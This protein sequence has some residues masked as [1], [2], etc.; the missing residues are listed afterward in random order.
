MYTTLSKLPN[1]TTRCRQ[2]RFYLHRFR[3]CGFYFAPCMYA[4]LLFTRAFIRCFP[5]YKLHNIFL[6]PDIRFVIA[7][8]PCNR[9]L[10]SQTGQPAFIATRSAG[11][12]FHTI[13]PPVDTENWLQKQTDALLSVLSEEK[14]FVWQK[15]WMDYV[16]ME[17]DF[18]ENGP[19]SINENRREST[20]CFVNLWILRLFL[21]IFS[22]RVCV[23]YRG[24]VDQGET[25]KHHC[26]SWHSLLFFEDIWY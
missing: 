9:P 10:Q 16:K 23:N 5:C 25:E 1:G 7:A 4:N 11:I 2:L 19:V 21:S 12:V 22:H 26:E 3:K 6:G 8:S 17:L 18:W 13:F 24:L 20:F 15:C 14:R